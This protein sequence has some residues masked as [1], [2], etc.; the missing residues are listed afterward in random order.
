MTSRLQKQ[1]WTC[2]RSA[3]IAKTVSLQLYKHSIN[4]NVNVLFNFMDC[5]FC[6]TSPVL[7]AI[8]L[9]IV[10]GSFSTFP[11]QNQHPI[12]D[13]RVICHSWLRRRPHTAVQNLVKFNHGASEQ[14]GEVIFIIG[15]S[16]TGQTAGRIFTL[17]GSNDANSR[18]HVPSGFCWHCTPKTPIGIF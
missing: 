2:R 6:H 18:K 14:I 13:H 12:T 9:L 11:R 3:N 1:S 17:D 5:C 16:P 7:I 8:G 4:E 15:N 10:N